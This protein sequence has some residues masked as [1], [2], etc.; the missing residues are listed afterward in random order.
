[1][2]TL[3]RI[4]I[5]YSR[6]DGRT[7]AEDFQ[8]KLK[9]EGI[10]AWRDLQDMQSGVILPQ[11]LRAI[12][13]AEHLVLILSRR[14][15]ESQWIKDEWSH[16]RWVGR[17]VSPLLADPTI[18]RR[19][20]PAWIRREEVYDI[21]EPE[22]WTKLISVLKG[23]GKIKPAPY[24][25]GD[26][27]EDFV[28]RE[29]KFTELKQAVLARRSDNT[30]V[31]LTTALIGAGGYGKTTLANYLCRDSDVQFEF[32]DGIVR[33]EIGKERG[34][35]I[36]LVTDL[37]E[38]LHPEGKR[39]GFTDIVTASEY[40]GELI[41][42]SR[43]LLVIDD[44]WRESQLR[45]FL[46]GGPN[47]VRLVTTRLPGQLPPSHVPIKV[48]EMRDAEAIALISRGLPVETDPV[49]R[50]RLAALAKRLENW[51]QALSMANR[52][53]YG[54]VS[55]GEKLTE[56][57][58]R[59][60]ERVKKRG[61]AGFDPKNEKQRD[62]AIGICIEV[63]LEDLDAG[64]RALFGELA[65]LPE[66]AN[67][68]LNI[69]EALWAES[70]DF[71]E[72]ETD[73]LVRRL[74][75]LSLLQDLDLGTKTLR[76][77]D[78]MAW[79]LRDRAGPDN[80]RAAHATMVKA[81]SKSCGGR[82]DKLPKEATYAWKFL[83]RHLRAAGQ[84]DKADGLLTDYAWV[85][86]KLH[87]TDATTLFNSYLPESPNVDARLV[88]Q[89]I[90]LSVPALAANRGEFARQIFGRLGHFKGGV[91]AALTAAA[92][93]D[94]EFYPAPR[95]PG[96]T[97]PGAERLRLTGHDG[98]VMSAAFSPN[99]QRIIT[100]SDD[101]TVRL[102]DATSGREIHVLSGLSGHSD[103][104]FS[105]SF[106]PDGSRIVTASRD[107]TA[108]VWDAES[109]KELHTLQGHD[110]FVMSASFS[111]DGSRVVTASL[112]G[113]AR[114]WDAASGDA[115]HVLTSHLE[116]WSA[117]FSPDGSRIVTS[118]LGTVWDAVSGEEIRTLPEQAG[119]VDCVSF[120]PDGSRIITASRDGTARVWDAT[121]D[122]EI[123]VLGHKGASTQPLMR[124][125][126]F[127]PDGKRIITAEGNTARL[128]NAA[129]GDEI[130][131]LRGHGSS[132]MSASFSPDG[133]RIVTASWDNTARAWDV[134]G[135][136][137]TYALRGHETG[138]ASVSLS[139]DGGRLVTASS[140]GT[141]RLW[142]AASG[143]E[144]CVLH[145]FRANSV[146]FSPDGSRIVT[147]DSTARV[148]DAA[149]GKEIYVLRGEDDNSV[150]SASFSPDGSGIV[151]G[152]F[153]GTVRL[154]DA[155]DGKELRIL[156][157]HKFPVNSGI[158]LA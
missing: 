61:L 86:A 85:K 1:M 77:H 87:A 132:V 48:D 34:D 76:L 65:V 68:P 44:V 138:V 119:I 104:M 29:L 130:R 22:R 10:H 56:A 116:E 45:P 143:E 83:I 78:N 135:D 8:R 4:F 103:G 110:N 3:P 109:N 113:T 64:E 89:A 80:Y 31:G 59:Y 134:V 13:D 100:A 112:D 124:S 42:K 16:A 118:A 126:S 145:K 58:E 136:E 133:N 69:I 25:P 121:S 147:A 2:E 115:I 129:S 55:L 128:W 60:D 47:C 50:I 152:S 107:G 24:M 75:H 158:V 93:T 27:P 142:D 15:L 92:R 73:E 51:A 14:A 82:W 94:A 9:S 18:E 141:V 19:E 154:W 66:D 53:I 28:A 84:D 148:W 30:T 155:A 114:V 17:R 108:R 49:A 46:R 149:S 97:P 111:P 74:S 54:R 151:T 102:W 90:A 79:Y 71:D 41:G 127:S 88:G 63:S 101:G 52:W 57:I 5:S 139:P 20:L 153:G 39:P 98:W 12:E 140:G 32:T 156:R 35:V 43:L 125:A 99:G 6:S 150:S 146:A 96:L 131:V 122:E 106:S 21:A 95:W 62:Q 23:P 67:V 70:K 137:E 81:L 38:R 7:F 144:I 37:I 11:V 33:V 117:S 72:D 120:S 105:A 26:L 123:Y 36:G 40:L 91:P 157:A